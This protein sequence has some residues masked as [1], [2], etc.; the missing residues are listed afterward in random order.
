MPILQDLQLEYG[1]LSGLMMQ[2]VAHALDIHPIEVEGVA[3]FYSFLNSNQKQGKYIIRLCRTISCDLA[4]KSR[5]ARQFENELGIQ[6]GETTK[7]GM[8]TL[9][10]TNCL[11]MCDQGPAVMVNDRL[12]ARVSPEKVPQI[13]ENCK[14]NF[15]KPDFPQIVP[16]DVQKTGP[17]LTAK[18]KFGEGLKKALSLARSDVIAEIRESGLKGRGGAGF[19]TAVKWQLAAAAVSDR[20]YVVCNADEGEPGTF[21]DR[22]LL[23]ER[24]DLLLAG[25]TVAA[26]VIGAQKGFIYLRG[27]YQYLKDHIQ[28]AIAERRSKNLLGDQILDKKDFSFHIELRMGSGA[29]VCGEE[30]ALIESLEGQRGEPRNRPPFPVDTGFEKHPTIVNNVETFVDAVL[31][32][33]KGAQWFKAHGT[34]KSTGT[35]L[36]SVSGDCLRPGVYELP[37]G[38]S[39][40]QLL[41]EVGGEGAKAIQI[42]G[43]SGHCVP[44]TEFGR[45]IAF[46]DIPSGGSIIVFGPDRD[47]LHVAI[48][49]MEFF[50]EESCGQCTPC[51]D[52]NVK[53]LEG[54]KLLEKGKCSS[55][56]LNELVKL[57]QTI[58]IASKC[59]LGQSSPTAFLSIIEHFKNE[60]LGRMPVSL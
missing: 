41:K 10:Y 52:G 47:M 7:D 57:G 42:G 20:K 43:A 27:E 37:F 51:R 17:I 36:F 28:T 4:G 25:M 21:K 48:N 54:L 33:T 39:I 30:T 6:F 8:F 55:S 49:F 19:P 3:S 58:Q 18:I 26:Y 59:G 1:I 31:I 15:L 53:M 12:F 22:Y 32:C 24:T 2:E 29:Y 40:S 35:K 11:G 46:E 13:I 23:H 44:A 16:S 50:S 60:L 34:E 14:R 38:I 56:Y 5:V 9:E 45:T